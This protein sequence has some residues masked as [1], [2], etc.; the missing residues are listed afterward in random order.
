MFVLFG[1][2]LIVLCI[3]MIV[4]VIVCLVVYGQDDA[5]VPLARVQEL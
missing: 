5:T 3:V 2:G 1:C 4:V